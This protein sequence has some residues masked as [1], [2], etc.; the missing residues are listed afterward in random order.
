MKKEVTMVDIMLE[1]MRFKR[2]TDKVY[3]FAND[4]HSEYCN[5]FDDISLNEE[6]TY[7]EKFNKL[8]QLYLELIEDFWNLYELKNKE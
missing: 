3:A 8:S 7:E 6:L 4:K 1:Q 5:S 2:E